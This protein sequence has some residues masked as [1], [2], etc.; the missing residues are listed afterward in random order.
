LNVYRIP[1]IIMHFTL[2]AVTPLVLL[3][4]IAEARHGRVNHEVEINRNWAGVNSFFLHAFPEYVRVA[5][6]T[7]SE[8]TALTRQAQIRP[9]RG[10]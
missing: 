4:S 5:N 7:Q 6:R 1:S 3:S 9:S 8:L 2:A 10:S